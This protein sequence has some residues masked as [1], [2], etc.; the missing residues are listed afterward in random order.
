MPTTFYPGNLQW[1]GLAKETTP[2]TPVTTPTM[3]IP[4]DSPKHSPK[5]MQ[6]VDTALRGNMA[7]QHQTIPGMAYE[8]LG[9]KTYFFNDSIYQHLMAM[10]GNPDTIT[11]SADPYTHK[12]SLYNGASGNNAQPPTYT[13]FLYEMDGKVARIPGMSMSS[14]KLSYKANEFPTLDVVWNGLVATYVTAPTNTPSTLAPMPPSTVS[15]TIGGVLTGAN[16]DISLDLKRDTKP[17]FVLNGTNV[18]LGI[19]AGPLT[20]SGSL[21]A[22]FQGPTDSH[23]VNLLTNAQP[24]LSIAIYRQGDATHPLTIQCSKIGYTS[25]DPQPSSNSW[26]TIQSNF[27]ALSNTT[28]ALDGKSSPIQAIFLS[29]QST[30]Y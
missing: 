7:T 29:A 22:V 17:I 20:V 25:S 8:E 30:A 9:Y 14:L 3:W 12:T 27:G 24:A 26:M 16:S 21:T 13:G 11:G 19:F 10:L 23:L 2:G 28:D 18:P 15:V 5:Q 6:L 1:L 4:V